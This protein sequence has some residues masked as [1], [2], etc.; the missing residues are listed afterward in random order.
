MYS[1]PKE[2]LFASVNSTIIKS[3]EYPLAA[4]AFINQECQRLVRL[5]LDLVLPCCG[6]CQNLP[7]ALTMALKILWDWDIVMY[8]ISKVSPNLFGF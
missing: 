1:L 6:I 5:V 2:E 7:L 3:I 4:S 8:T